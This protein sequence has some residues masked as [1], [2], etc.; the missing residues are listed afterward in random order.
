MSSKF[1]GNRTEKQP[2]RK[3]GVS[4]SLITRIINLNQL[5]LGKLVEVDSYFYFKRIHFFD[6]QTLK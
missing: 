5:E 4:K 3:K 1:F 2:S 6:I